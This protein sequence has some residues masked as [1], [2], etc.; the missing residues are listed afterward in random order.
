MQHAYAVSWLVSLVVL[1]V[2]MQTAD[3]QQKTARREVER[4]V[5]VPEDNTPFKVEE[6][7][8][9]RLTGKGIAGAKFQI[10]VDGPARLAAINQIFPRRDGHPLIG[11]GNKEFEIRQGEGND[12][13]YTAHTGGKTD[14][15]DVRVWRGVSRPASYRRWGPPINTMLGRRC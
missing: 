7:D 4:S 2:L 6:R 15:G 13:Q 10:K 14:R 8:T 11:L 1:G 3:S 12:N 5:V 9:V